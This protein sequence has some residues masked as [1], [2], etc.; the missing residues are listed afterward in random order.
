MKRHRKTF[1][2]QEEFALAG[3]RTA[4]REFTV[5]AQCE[6]LPFL[7]NLPLNLSRKQAKDLL[8]F[9]AVTLHDRGKVQHD[10]QLHPGEIVHVLL[11]KRVHPPELAS[12]GLDILHL[13]DAVVVVDKPAGLLAMG[14]EREKERTAHRILNERLKILTKSHEQQAFIVHRLDRETSG[15][16]LF[17]R[18]AAVQAALQDDWKNV[19]KKYFAVVAGRPAERQ[20]TLRDHL[21]ES[22]SFIVRP[23]EQGGELAITN[24]RVL[25]SQ[26]NK[27]LLEL[28]L[29][30]GRK[31]QIRV[32]LA[33]RGYPILGDR[34]YGL[35]DATTRRLALH[36]CYL[37]FRHPVS[38]TALEVRSALPGQL[39]ALMESGGTAMAMAE[40]RNTR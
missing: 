22:K 38:G 34:K 5:A 6:L 13:D 17:A 37:R 2:P 19:T 25:H 31:H 14:S 20:G 11:S 27:A 12:F 33:S 1:D 36:A 30:T 9:R 15:L 21:V 7:T 4:D 18:T 8:R 40:P 28:T 16:M 24:Y 29:E 23:V 10:T 26:K 3:K 32:Q 35:K 39:K